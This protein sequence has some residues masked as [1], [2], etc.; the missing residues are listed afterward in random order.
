[1]NYKLRMQLLQSIVADFA[2]IQNRLIIHGY[3]QLTNF[4]KMTDGLRKYAQ[5]SKLSVSYCKDYSKYLFEPYF[6]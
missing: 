5:S 3:C 4:W 1:M 6:F 2:V